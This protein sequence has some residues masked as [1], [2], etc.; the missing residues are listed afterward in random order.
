MIIVY[1]WNNIKV[2]CLQLF[3]RTSSHSIIIPVV[4]LRVKKLP[5][6]FCCVL[7]FVQIS[8]RETEEFL[9]GLRRVLTA[10]PSDISDICLWSCRQLMTE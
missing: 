1:N 9:W 8:E 7:T 4:V 6:D 10:G 3:L 2:W 5:P